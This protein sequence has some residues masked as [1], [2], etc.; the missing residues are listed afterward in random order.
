MSECPYQF[1]YAAIPHDVSNQLIEYLETYITEES[2]YIVALEKCQTHKHTNGEHY[3]FALQIEEKKLQA[4]IKKVI[5]GIYKC[6]GKNGTG[7]Y[8]GV[9]DIK[10]IR[11]TTKFLAYTCKDQNL[12]Y[13]NI[14]PETI[15]EYI[16]K[17]YKK[18]EDIIEELMKHL[19]ASKAQYIACSSPL[20]VCPT[21]QLQIS[22]IEI[23]V[24]KFHMEKGKRICKSQIKNLVLTYLQLHMEDRWKHLD[25]I[26]CYTI[27]N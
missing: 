9:Q 25:Q 23:E 22:N 11:D 19:S 4:F 10:K 12:I 26:Y 16:E 5:K 1:L 20:K 13:K 2:S 27:N 15:A 14:T 17:S 3:H 8:Y 7:P 24:L 6:T 18:K 21:Y